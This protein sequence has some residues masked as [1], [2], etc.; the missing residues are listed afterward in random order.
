[1]SDTMVHEKALELLPWFVN[2]TLAAR[3]RAEVERHIRGCVPCRIALQEQRQLQALIQEQPTV[4]LSPEK[5][6][7][8]LLHEVDRPRRRRTGA[9]LRGWDLSLSLGLAPWTRRAVTIAVLVLS[10]GL[11]S[12]MLTLRNSGND[13]PLYS[14]S[15]QSPDSTAP[16]ID[17]VFADGLPEDEMRTL[18]RSIGGTIVAGPSNV[19]RYTIRL[20]ASETSPEQLQAVLARLQEDARVRFAGRAFRKDPTQ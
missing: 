5:G 16:L 1:M 11:A 6:F 2:G 13:L 19:G 3:E 7:A 10:F 17:I 15:S 8:D 18:V 9:T 4:R 14:T 12:W 20:D